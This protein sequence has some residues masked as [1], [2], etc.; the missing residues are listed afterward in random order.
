MLF[1]LR[2]RYSGEEIVP[3][4]RE[5]RSKVRELWFWPII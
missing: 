5:R 2:P 4:L 3:T 1:R